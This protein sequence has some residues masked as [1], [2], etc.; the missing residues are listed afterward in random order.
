MRDVIARRVALTGTRGSALFALLSIG[1]ACGRDAPPARSFPPA[2]VKIVTV[3][4]RTLPQSYDLMGEVVPSR[5]VE[6]RARVEGVVLERPFTEGSAVKAGQVLYR[7]DR[8]RNAAANAGA[9]ARFTN[10]QSTLARLEPLLPKH[11]VAQQDV[12][13]A[14]AEL[15]SAKASLDQVRKDLDDAVVRAEVSGRVGAARVEVGGRV[16]GPA[17]LLTT[18]D[19]VDPV[20]VIFRPSI[21]QLLDWRADPASARLLQPGGALDVRVVLPNDSLLPRAGRLTFV[22]PSLDSTTGTQAFRAT[23]QNADRILVPGQF[24]TVRLSG[25][26]RRNAL[27]VP[28][29]AV[30]QGLGRQFVYLVADGDTVV[31][32]DVK[33]GPWSGALWIIEHG[34]SA[35]DRVVVDG[36][37]KAAPGRVVKPSPLAG[38][39]P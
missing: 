9:L 3:A 24:V 23:F 26:A 18:I 30:Q 38:P 17:D 8:V 11:A 21:Q 28:Q 1:A 22:S 35:G 4:P 33:T 13:N 10:A 37:Q 7:L 32:R 12:D 20:Y 15:E 29:R 5:R 16:T 31:T 27:A 39:T 34:L 2:D 25:F 36:L 14:R 6:V 19:D